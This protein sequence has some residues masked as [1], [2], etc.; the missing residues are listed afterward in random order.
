MR[1][2]IKPARSLLAMALLIG[3]L[4]SLAPVLFERLDHSWT[5]Y[6]CGRGGRSSTIFP[7]LQAGP[8]ARAVDLGEMLLGFAGLGFVGYRQRK[9]LAGSANV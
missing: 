6:F 9:K 8:S 3:P 2:T 1:I 7:S 5:D 4:A